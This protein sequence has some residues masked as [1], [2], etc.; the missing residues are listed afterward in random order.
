LD[1]P[2]DSVTITVV[3]EPAALVK[4]DVAVIADEAESVREGAEVLV[5]ATLKAILGG[6]CTTVP[7]IDVTINPAPTSPPFPPSVIDTS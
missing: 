6:V 1:V 5:C 7:R 2:E 3:K 4:A